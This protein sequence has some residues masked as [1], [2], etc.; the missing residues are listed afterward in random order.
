MRWRGL[1]FRWQ[2]QQPDGS[3]R[4]ALC[5]LVALIVLAGSARSEGVAENVEPA[6]TV[7]GPGERMVYGLSYGPVQAGEATL[8]V[9]GLTTYQGHT[10]YQLQSKANSNRFFSSIYKVRDKIVSYLDVETLYT[11]YFFKRL[12]EGDYRKTVEVAFDQDGEVAHYADGDTVATGPRVQDI[13]S[14]LFFLRNLDLA[15]GDTY[16]L[17]A[18][19]SRKTYDLQ[20]AVRGKKSIKVAAG[21]FD[22]FVVEPFLEGEGLFKH[23]GKITIYVTDDEHR[24]PVLIRAKVPVGAIEVE[25]KEYQP[26]SPLRKRSAFTH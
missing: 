2:R 6:P 9:L 16:S 25:L 8:E 15:S 11:R 14:A 1:H 10:C 26:G 7:F 21:V 24:V 12:R 22:C 19:S 4:C 17:L 13:L 20:I 5:V 23:E 18:H 3:V